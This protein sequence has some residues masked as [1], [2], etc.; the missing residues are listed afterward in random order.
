MRPLTSSPM[1]LL[2]ATAPFLPSSGYNATGPLVW[3]LVIVH[4]N[5]IQWHGKT[6]SKPPYSSGFDV[7]TR[8]QMF[9]PS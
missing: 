5:F 7:Y 6:H 4:V 9:P 3:S 1:L 8:S 2:S